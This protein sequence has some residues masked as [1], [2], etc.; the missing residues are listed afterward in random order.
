[1]AGGLTAS[2]CVWEDLTL[3]R[4]K[5]WDSRFDD[6]SL[7][8]PGLTRSPRAFPL[9]RRFPCAP[10]YLSASW[11]SHDG[12][13]GSSGWLGSHHPCSLVRLMFS[14]GTFSHQPAEHPSCQRTTPASH[15]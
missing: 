9:A 13:G 5:P 12:P 8:V 1:M 2:R 14:G 4:L 11:T 7:A 3:P 15:I 6:H 10:R